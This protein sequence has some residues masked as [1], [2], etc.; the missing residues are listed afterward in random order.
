MEHLKRK[1]KYKAEKPE[2]TINK[3]RTVLSEKL[4][5]LLE[6]S[7]FQSEGGFYSS[8]I[9]IGN[10]DLRKRDLGTNGKGMTFPY[11]LASAYGEF[12]E[13][14]QNHAIIR[15]QSFAYKYSRFVENNEIYK[16]IIHENGVLLDYHY[17]ADEKRV[18]LTSDNATELLGHI[19][20]FTLNT[21]IENYRGRSLTM[22]PFYNATQ[23]KIEKLPYELIFMNCTSNGM[24]AGNT[25]KEA[26][27]QG[28]SEIIERYIL[29][30]IYRNGISLPTIP[31]KYFVGTEILQK[32]SLLKEKYGPNW[33]F[34]IKDC[35]LGKNYPA[36]G[37]LM[38]NKMEL[39]YLFHLGV[40]PSPI[41]ALERSLTE[42]Y[43][44]RNIALLLD[45]DFAIQYGMMN[46]NKIK[47]AQFYKT[48]TVGSGHYPISILGESTN[49]QFNGFD[50]SWGQSDEND[51][52][53]LKVLI[54]KDGYEIF[55]RDVSFLGFPAYCIYIPGMTEFRNIFN[56]DENDF[57]N[58]E[59][60]KI[61]SAAVNLYE[62]KDEDI[63]LLIKLL[64]KG[65][66]YI[67]KI[68]D[69]DL[70]SFLTNYDIDLVLTILY[71]IISD[72][73]N[74][75]MHM[76][77]Y[78]KKFKGNAKEKLFFNSLHDYLYCKA[79]NL[80]TNCL[81]YVYSEST[82]GLISDFTNGKAALNY[83]PYTSFEKIDWENYCQA[84]PDYMGLLKLMK[85]MEQLYSE[86]IP[87]Q[88]NL[89]SSI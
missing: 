65:Q 30:E 34:Q 53:M 10:L 67:S 38:Y 62:A 2:V 86:N 21:L 59:N 42:I 61:I 12:M 64:I 7:N 75:Y 13:R 51:L 88:A 89:S 8:R 55:V 39:K 68:M 41:T 74:A 77:A 82:L 69:Y 1:K 76:A 73:S 24:C 54:E 31:D 22:L 49:M 50:S 87:N 81:N 45:I 23:K 66:R 35:S 19:R 60:L 9:R 78:K 4:G 46:D 72:V 18:E 28:I 36:V 5:I 33:S 44:G 80:D 84:N 63:K 25:P 11:S 37:I 16:K 85:K 32:I 6:D 48:C 29:R 71:I 3:I 79:N 52:L 83:I 47:D 40:D 70:N 17:A 20:G 57:F 26:L 15:S 56:D 27:I 58:A 14:M 43:Q